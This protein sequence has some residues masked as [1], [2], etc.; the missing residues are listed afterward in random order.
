MQ[1]ISVIIP[2][3]NRAATIK[4]AIDSVLNQTVPVSEILICDDGSTDNSEELIKEF[5]DERIKWVGGPH[6]GHPAV[7]RNRG[8][9]QSKCEWIAFLDSDDEWL[10]NKL[11]IQ[12][13]LINQTHLPAVCTNA[14]RYLPNDKAQ[15]KNLLQWNQ[16]T[17]SLK[18]LATYNKIVC[19]SVLIRR[20]LLEKAGGF[21]ETQQL[22]T[23]QDYALWLRVAT[24]TA[25]AYVNTPLVAYYDN[26]SESVRAFRP[27]SLVQRKRVVSSFLAWNWQKDK[28]KT[29]VYALMFLKG[30][31][32]YAISK[33]FLN[34][35]TFK[36]K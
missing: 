11:Q 2:T 33:I 24:L 22:R 17:I 4:R 19:S 15:A 26:P 12:F 9:Q 18:D 30:I 8:L 21:P 25:F 29:M 5:Q 13:D 7:P 35:S 34:L 20:E 6:S 31:A 3:W 32:Q 14:I 27:K 36:F 28:F 1:A 10:P 23:S 16:T